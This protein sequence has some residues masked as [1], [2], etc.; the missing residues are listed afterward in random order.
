[1]KKLTLFC[2][3]GLFG[4]SALSASAATLISNLGQGTGIVGNFLNTSYAYATDFTTD[5]SSAWM[6]T[7]AT[8][9]MGNGDNIAHTF[10]ASIFDDNAGV[11]GSLIGSFNFS[12]AA[13]FTSYSDASTSFAGITLLANHTYWQVL[14]MNEAIGI[15]SAPQW[16]GNTSEN[17]DAGSVFTT[18]P[19]TALKNSTNGG[20]TYSDVLFFGSPL[21]GNY[22][23]ALSG[24]S[25]P[26]PS[27]GMLLA[28]AASSALGLWRRR[29][30]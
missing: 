23:F 5:A 17:T 27:S 21:H 3:I 24:S 12:I 6:V 20:A 7:G 28:V 9:K 26:E 15:G 30:G 2:G 29:G 4:L 19:S 1:M 8:F 22:D 10:T 25:V 11:P 16:A 14:Q 13:G 18:V